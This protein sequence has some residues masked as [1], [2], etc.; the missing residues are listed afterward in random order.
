VNT[1][2][3]HLATQIEYLLQDS[4]FGLNGE[5]IMLTL[6]VASALNLSAFRHERDSYWLTRSRHC[7]MAIE[8]LEWMYRDRELTGAIVHSL[9][10]WTAIA[11]WLISLRDFIQYL[12]SSEIVLN[13]VRECHSRSPILMLSSS[14]IGSYMPMIDT[15]GGGTLSYLPWWSTQRNR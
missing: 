2:L 14:V 4:H 7:T 13:V 9:Y 5:A 12:D 6:G 15:R 10:D 11:S 3:S 1:L 8:L